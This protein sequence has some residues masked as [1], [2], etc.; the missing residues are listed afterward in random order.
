MASERGVSRRAFLRAGIGVAGVSL[1]AACAP[2]AP[3]TK[4]AES[5]PAES[6]PAATKPAETKPAEAAKPAAP[7][8][9]APAAKPTA[10]AAAKPAE[11]AKPAAQ[12][13][14]KPGEK[15]GANLIGKVEGPTILP[16]AKR[17]A[18]LAEAPMLAELVKAGKLPPV[19]QRVPEE[20]LVVKPLHEIGKYGGM[21]RRAFTGPADGENFNRVMGA[22]K[23]LHVDFTGYKVIPAVMKSWELRDGG[24]TI[25]LSLR[26]GMKWSDGQP[27]T[28]D[29]VMFWY[30]DFYMNKE[31]TPVGTAEMTINGKPGEIVKVDDQTVEARFPEPYPMFVD[32]LSAFTQVGGG[33]AL[34][35]SQW[36]GFMGFYAPA[37]YLKQFHP[38]Y[39][40]ADKA[41]QIARDAGIDGWI[42]LLKFKNNY[43]LNPEVP[44]LTPWKTVQPINTPVWTLERN[45]YYFGVDSEGNQL[46]Y[47]DKI[48]L[49]LAEN[50]EVANLRGIAGEFDEMG[51]HMDVAKLPIFLENQE[52][53]NYKVRLDLSS[54]A[55]AVAIHVN[56]SFEAD[57]EIRKWLTNVDFRRALSMGIDRDQFNEAFFLGMATPSSLMSEDASPENAGPEWRTKWSTLDV[58]QSN[59]LL[60]KIGLTKK[61][62]EGFRVR[63]D[64]GQRLRVE[65]TTVAAA[66]LPYAQMMEMVAQQW[67]KI[68]IQLDVK[69]T[70]RALSVR[71]VAN[72][73]QQL[74]VWG[75]GN[76]DI[77]LWPRHDMPA[78][79]NEP[80]SGTL[81]ASWYASGGTA[82]KKPDDPEL[83]K[84]YDMLRKAAGL[85]TPERNKLGQELKKLIVDQ[86]WVIGTVGFAP[87]LRVV[88]NKLENVPERYAWLTRCRTP[89]AVHPSTYFFKS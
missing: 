18:K 62:S 12:A 44:V 13:A 32:I 49:T 48:Q 7:A 42:Q 10:A 16:D 59:Q 20:P 73:E 66:F 19:E 2:Q 9:T 22:E 26:K 89:G 72:N 21:W 55:A 36:G 45:P 75:G 70:E 53:G 46:P 17:P 84:A 83:L 71:K 47:I 25:R 1:L 50:L 4:P 69:D 28:A 35:G 43:Q 3:A 82:G 57:P 31:I 39:I 23:P 78:E 8:T 56:Q 52:K 33:H 37:H 34:G 68:G 61:D 76:A 65:V 60:D 79:P 51:R 81:Y 11:A 87:V 74:Y 86:Q 58:S 24:K 80:F 14:P 30:E 63:T 6:K 5:K 88:S 85:E 40:G 15:L 77:F 29:D 64:N 27:F 67:K 38:K 54:D 41:T